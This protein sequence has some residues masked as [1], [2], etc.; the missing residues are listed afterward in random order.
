M[1]LGYFYTRFH[2]ERASYARMKIGDILSST[3]VKFVQ[4]Q[5]NYLRWQTSKWKINV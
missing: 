2:Y 4:F 1:Y 5:Q 3:R